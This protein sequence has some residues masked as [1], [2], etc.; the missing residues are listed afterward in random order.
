MRATSELQELAPG[1]APEMAGEHAHDLPL[2]EIYRKHGHMVLRRAQTILGDRN[3]ALDVLQ[4]IF[5][6]LVDDPQQFAGRSAVTTWLYRVTTNTCLN[7]LR[8]RRNRARLVRALFDPEQAGHQRDASE[9]VMAREFIDRMP[10]ELAQVTI[11]H[12]VD[13]MT[14]SEIA[15]VL[16]CS[17]RH[18]GNL[19]ERAARWARSADEV[20]R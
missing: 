11:Y 5:L 13:G 18:V 9:W 17:R 19:L 14:Q 6:S 8:D 16:G 12:A 2:A 10:V 20:T 1:V 7:R 15:E 4:Q 3:E